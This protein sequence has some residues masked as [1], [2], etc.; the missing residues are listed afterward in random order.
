M[1]F[2]KE[3]QAQSADKS[4]V[5]LALLDELKQRACYAFAE[6]N[7][8]CIKDDI[9]G[10]AKTN[11]SGKISGYREIHMG[12]ISFDGGYLE[13]LEYNYCNVTFEFTG[14]II[15][16]TE[17]EALGYKYTYFVSTNTSRVSRAIN[18]NPTKSVVSTGKLKP[19]FKG[20]QYQYSLEK[21]AKIM[22]DKIIEI[23][24]KD[25]ITITPLFA[26]Q[27]EDKLGFNETTYVNFDIPTPRSPKS[28]VS[29]ISL[30]YE[31]EY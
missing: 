23:A 11:S 12:K 2:L 9:L 14:P 31:V 16:Y 17:I 7:L 30:K 6:F 21:N 8:R 22:V 29:Y 3:L 26:N 28:Y 27:Y 1:S 19:L 13:R 25:S 10:R 24:K 20:R 5:D 15:N 18:F 4:K